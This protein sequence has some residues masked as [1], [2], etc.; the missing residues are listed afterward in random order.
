MI[1]WDTSALVKCYAASEAGHARAKNLLLKEKGHK[2]SAFLRLETTSAI[3]RKL[4]TDRRNRD[5]LLSLADEHL[6]YFDLLRI[7]PPLLDLARRLIL[8][9]SLTTADAIHLGA[10]LAL[11]RDLGKR[12]LRFATAD[13][14][15]AEAARA[16]GLKVIDIAA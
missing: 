14:E 5:S 7:D 12:S 1:F 2:G 13:G 9:H 3:V 4:G 6:R 10:A 11:A 15:Q 16:E 8:K